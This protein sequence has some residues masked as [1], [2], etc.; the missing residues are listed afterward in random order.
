[1][2]CS[3]ARILG[4]ILQRRGI[5]V[6]ALSA[7]IFVQGAS[8]QC[9]TEDVPESGKLTAN[10]T[11]PTESYPGDPIQA[12]VLQVESGWTHNWASQ[13]ASQN[14]F[15]TMLRLGAWC[16]LE[17]RWDVVNYL[18]M[19]S[20]AGANSGFGDNFLGGQYRF[21]RET[22]HRPSLSL[23]YTVKF[24]SANPANGLGSGKMDQAATLMLGKT[25]H[26][27]SILSNASYFSIGQ[28]TGGN[29]AK[30]EATLAISHTLKGKWGV[31]GEIY[32][33]SRIN[34]ASPS[35]VNSTWAITYNIRPRIVLDTGSY[36]GLTAGPC[37]P[38]RSYFVGVTY[39]MGTLFH[40]LDPRAG[41]LPE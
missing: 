11:R 8:A 38:G 30:G 31:V 3:S 14:S 4:W 22:S 25:L 40:P 27:F 15:G 39:A 20:P 6:A 21:L 5:L 36:L 34:A 10:P 29:R 16:N 33:D 28:P 9:H 18:S 13:D 35:Y 7:I 32:G 1:M 12:G 37:S 19:T 2:D 17:V 41:R 24:P 23:G 26:G